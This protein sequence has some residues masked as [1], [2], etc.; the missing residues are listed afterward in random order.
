M[1]GKI[2]IGVQIIFLNP[3]VMIE[4]HRMKTQS[5]H[6]T[7]DIYI[8]CVPEHPH[9][10]INDFYQYGTP[11]GFMAYKKSGFAGLFSFLVYK[12]SREIKQFSI[13]ENRPEGADTSKEDK[14]EQQGSDKKAKKLKK[15]TPVGQA[16][17]ES[18]SRDS[19]KIPVDID[20]NLELIKQSFNSKENKDIIIR[21]F[22]VAGKYKAFIA[23]IDGMVD[24]ITI[25]NFILR[26]LLRKDEY[27]NEVGTGCSLDYIFNDVLE[28]NQATKVSD[29]EDVIYEILMGNTCLYVDGCD[30]YISSE[31]KGYDKRSVEKPQTEGVV[32][33]AQ[34]AFNENLRTNITLVRRIVKNK[35]LTTEFLKVGRRNKNLCAVMYINGLIN[36]AIVKEVKRRIQGLKTD[37]IAGSGILEQFIEENPRSLVPTIL[38]TE[39][40]DRAASHLVEGKAVIIAEGTPFALVVPVSLSAMFHTP[41]DSTLRWQYGTL[42]RLIRIFA[43]LITT[44][45]PGLYVALTNFHREMIPTDLL[46]AIAKARENVPFPTIFE[47]FLMEISFEL[48]REAGIRI[49]GIIGNTIGI[50]GA[51]ILGQAAVQAN[52]V[53][54]VLIIVVA[55]TGL[56]NFAIPDFGMAFA[57]RI[58]RFIFIIL[59]AMLGFYGISLG[60]VGLLAIL[61]DTRSFGVPFLTYFSPKVSENNDLIIRKPVWKQEDRPDDVN[62]LDTVRQPDISK[63]WLYE[64]GQEDTGTQNKTGAEGENG[65]NGK[66]EEDEDE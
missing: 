19:K 41:E 31:T 17:K 44:F 43:V 61:A 25:N 53:S 34:E 64:E 1:T 6:K 30:F 48:I 65:K 26:P 49:P 20:G 50:I 32:R 35:D 38:S 11:E 2:F 14:Q 3:L 10:F 22:T 52:L 66:E 46:I 40:P 47:V 16:K 4:M 7:A 15:P 57:A 42:L 58:G 27:G 54:P 13:P 8:L 29:I 21:Q 56:G 55:I 60:V 9:V 51:L 62:P 33:G 39:R 24:R 37:F 28:T 45:S 59:G 12:K 36:P 18:S 23:Y 63:E 5:K